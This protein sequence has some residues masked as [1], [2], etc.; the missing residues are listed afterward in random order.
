[1]CLIRALNSPLLDLRFLSPPRWSHHP[2]RNDALAKRPCTTWI[3][4]CG[5]NW[6]AALMHLFLTNVNE[7]SY[8][9]FSLL[10]CRQ[11]HKSWSAKAN[12][13]LVCSSPAFSFFIQCLR[14]WVFSWFLDFYCRPIANSLKVQLAAVA[15]IYRLRCANREQVWVRIGRNK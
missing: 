8:C 3:I 4:N 10:P 1:M 6:M 2:I 5:T 14:V 11:C 9:I 13:I 15:E 12:F 7:L